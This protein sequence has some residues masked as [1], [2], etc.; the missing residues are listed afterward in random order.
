MPKYITVANRP[1]QIATVH[2]A[3]CSYL[4]EAP[5]TKTVSAERFAFEDGLEAIS[6]ARNAMPSS[7]GWCRHCLAGLHWLKTN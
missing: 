3:T 1:N 6:A 7:F 2:V 4:G 5:L